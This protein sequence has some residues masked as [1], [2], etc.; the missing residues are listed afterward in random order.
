MFEPLTGGQRRRDR[1]R[2]LGLGL[3]ITK[4][5]A[6]AHGG[7]V[8]VSSSEAEGTTF[9]VSLPRFAPAAAIGTGVRDR[10]RRTPR[11]RAFGVNLVNLAQ[12]QL[13]DSEARFRLLVEAVKDYAI[14]MLDPSGRVATWNAGAQ[15]IKGY[16]ARRDHRPALLALLP[17]GGRRAPASASGSWRARPREGRFEDEGWRVRKDG[18]RFWAN[19]VI[20]A[21]RDDDRASC[22]ASPR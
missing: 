9:T 13:R 17:A 14:F 16:E 2:G 10:S 22:S 18:T 4:R 6:A 21:L 7:D 3:F 20:T 12:N 5:L 15:R 8:E 1:S 19:V 11:R